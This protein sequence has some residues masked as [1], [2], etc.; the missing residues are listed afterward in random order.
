[1]ERQ[2]RARG[3]APDRLLV[4]RGAWEVFSKPRHSHDACNIDGVRRPVVSRESAVR[5]PSMSVVLRQSPPRIR[6][7]PLDLLP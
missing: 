5:L 3:K 7:S 6:Y 4:I 2:T 1:M